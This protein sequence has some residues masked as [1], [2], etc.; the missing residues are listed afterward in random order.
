MGE[1]QCSLPDN[2]P[3]FH[4]VAARL[5]NLSHP[6]LHDLVFNRLHR[7]STNELPNLA[8][9]WE[10]GSDE[11]PADILIAVCD[12]YPDLASRFK[13]VCRQ[14]LEEWSLDA[15]TQRASSE[16]LGELVWFSARINAE[17]TTPRIAEIAGDSKFKYV[18]LSGGEDLQSRALRA[19]AGLLVGQPQET[20]S[21][22]RHL[23]EMA[24]HSGFHTPI[25]LTTLVGFWPEDKDAIVDQA[26]EHNREATE[27][28]LPILDALAEAFK[29]E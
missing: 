4:Q 10:K 3:S 17:G 19:L 12:N 28:I 23:F 22:Y 24:L 18:Q 26:R 25:G 27:K 15:K 21:N 14:L 16:P 7:L 8:E 9:P 6:Q 29:Q 5:S 20:R 2:R 1:R 11:D 13:T